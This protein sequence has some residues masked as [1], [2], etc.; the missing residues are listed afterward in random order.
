MMKTVLL[1]LVSAHLGEPSSWPIKNSRFILNPRRGES[2]AT[3][4]CAAYFN[5]PCAIEKV[6]QIVYELAALFE[7]ASS[8]VAVDD[9]ISGVNAKKFNQPTS[10]WPTVVD[11]S[12]VIVASGVPI[13]A[14][15]VNRTFVSA[16]IAEGRVQ[17]GKGGILQPL[18]FERL[19]CATDPSICPG[20]GGASDG[21]FLY[22]GY[23]GYHGNGIR[24][25]TVERINYATKVSRYPRWHACM[26]PFCSPIHMNSVFLL[27]PRA[28][29]DTPRGYLY[30]ISGFSNMLYSENDAWG[31]CSAS[32]D[33]LCSI[34]IVRRVPG[35]VVADMIKAPD[36]G[37]LNSVFG[38]ISNKMYNHYTT[39]ASTQASTRLCG[40]CQGEGTLM[41]QMH[42]DLWARTSIRLLAW[43]SPS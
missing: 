21:Y 30:V 34:A 32:R 19:Q 16:V 12:G 42:K 28:Q 22:E 43:R 40:G 41:V 23:G 8:T 20:G 18:L 10:F 24:T 29:V 39:T 13:Q 31:K 26:D 35:Q 2:M 15:Y 4:V 36:R 33:A 27:G 5:T 38:Q 1:I 25:T 11:S 7:T 37:T 6:H 17:E 9:I 14:A 3:A